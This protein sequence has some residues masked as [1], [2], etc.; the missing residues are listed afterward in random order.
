[1]CLSLDSWTQDFKQINLTNPTM[2]IQV[3]ENADY[4]NDN[5]YL[6]RSASYRQFYFDG[7]QV[8]KVITPQLILSHSMTIITWLHPTAPDDGHFNVLNKSDESQLSPDQEV[9]HFGRKDTGRYYISQ[10]LNDVDSTITTTSNRWLIVTV[11]LSADQNAIQTDVQFYIKDSDSVSTAGSVDSVSTVDW[12]F[13]DVNNSK[14]RIGGVYLVEAS[15]NSWIAHY[16]GYLYQL[17]I[18]N[19]ALDLAGVESKITGTDYTF[20]TTCSDKEN[21]YD[22]SDA[23][24]KSCSEDCDEATEECERDFNICSICNS[25]LCTQCTSSDSGFCFACKPEASL[26]PPAQG[27][28]ECVP[29]FFDDTLG[30]CSGCD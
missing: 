26:S 22:S 25:A 23:T 13:T 15:T 24:C 20:S 9:F 30:G 21:T 14:G 27:N 10:N 1:M 28:C 8:L 18:Y 7:G 29:G 16:T 12:Y 4:E 11:V 2:N 19:T 17:C 5:P 3:G 6:H